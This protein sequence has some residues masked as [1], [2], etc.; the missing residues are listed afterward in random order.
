MKTAIIKT[1][2]WE[3]DRIFNLLPDARYFYLCLLTNPKRGTLPAFKCSDRLMSAYTGYNQDTLKLCRSHLT[4]A[5]LITI[6]GEYYIINDDDYVKPTK[7]KLTQQLQDKELQSLPLDV[8]EFLL[9]RSGAVHE[10]NNNDNNNNKNIT[11]TKSKDKTKKYNKTDVELTELL[12]KLMQENTPH[13]AIRKPKDS[14]YEDINKLNRLDNAPYELIKAVIEWCQQ[15]DFWKNN[16][17]STSKLRQHYDRLEL[18]ARKYYNDK[19]GS[20]TVVL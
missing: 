13:R 11:I 20:R 17:R 3:E 1:D 8:R 12:Y 16:I 4:K 9:S 6:M 5:K 19:Q 7:G 10:Y 15:D 14:D 2:F 18:S